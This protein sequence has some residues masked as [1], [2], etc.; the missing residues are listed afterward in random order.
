MP[1]L[2]LSAAV[3]VLLLLLDDGSQ[4]RLV[5]LLAKLFIGHR[6]CFFHPVLAPL[7]A[8]V[9]LGAPVLAGSERDLMLLTASGDVWSS[10]YHLL[11][12]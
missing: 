10:F 8:A 11:A 9:R 4:V 1:Q 6:H 3:F 5:D 12:N 2:A 7:V